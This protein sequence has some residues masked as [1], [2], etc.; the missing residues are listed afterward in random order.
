M[1]YLRKCTVCRLEATSERDLNLF[2]KRS[3]AKYGRENTC[4]SCMN[5]RKKGQKRLTRREFSVRL[6][7]KSC[8]IECKTSGDFLLF[9]RYGETKE[10]I[11]K[12][13]NICKKCHNRRENTSPSGLLRQ[14]RYQ[15]KTSTKKKA[16]KRSNCLSTKT[17]LQKAD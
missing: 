15:S 17:F 14:K 11:P 3:K 16:H 1:S 6:R 10:G 12:F 4:K 2:V 9:K 5:L 8:G 7:C 13:R